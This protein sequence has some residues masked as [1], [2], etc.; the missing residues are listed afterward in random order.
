[1]VRIPLMFFPPEMGRKIARKT[2]GIGSIFARLA[3][4]LER[5][6]ESA[7]IPLH[8]AEFAGMSVL[9][10]L[11]FFA[12]FFPLLFTLFFRVQGRLLTESLGLGLAGGLG[13]GFMLF[14]VTLRYPRILAGKK[15]EQLNKSLVFALKDLLLQVSS[16]V[17]FYNAMAHISRS[18]YGE[19]SEEADKLC[20]KVDAGV[21]VDIALERMA[22]ETRSDYLRRS[23]WQI[24]NT[25]RAG[26]SL[27]ASIRT[28]INDLNRDQ[29]AKIREYA[30]ELNMLSLIYMLFAVAIPTIG[31]TLLIILSSF[32]GMG[33]NEI[34]IITFVSISFA[35][36]I[37]MIGF[38]KSRRPVVEF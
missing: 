37:V 22:L 35:I 31:I 11:L 34:T 20:R 19:M 1:M 18:G 9:N 17:P 32:A 5:D 24:L 38:I 16:G 21:S 36:Q 8:P 27:E 13:I 2:M 28:I 12:L 4:T 33:V 6:L 29:R 25:M 26:A 10:G 3:P 14:F 30:Q 15:G 7:K 23:I